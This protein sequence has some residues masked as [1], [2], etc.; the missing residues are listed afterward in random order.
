[1]CCGPR[2]A[3]PADR[4]W[5]P[6]GT[7]PTSSRWVSRAWTSRPPPPWP[8][9]VLVPPPTG[10]N[11]ELKQGAWQLLAAGDTRCISQ[12]ETPGMQGLLRRV[13]DA[14][15]GSPRPGLASLEDLAQLLALWRPGAYARERE[16]AYFTA[17]FGSQRPAL[18]HPSLAPIL[19]PTHGEL[20][21]ADQVVADHSTLRLHACLGRS[22][23]SRA[24]DRTPGG[25]L[26]HGARAQGRRQ[27][28]PLDRRAA[29]QHPGPAPG[30][31]RLP[32]RPRPRPGAREARLSTKPASSSIPPRARPS[33]PRP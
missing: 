22:L 31:R 30:A 13:R 14:A 6:P 33:S 28:P 9:P 24:G 27:A 29:Q 23:P 17:R 5:C 4:Y 7:N 21:Y 18:L 15:E 2:P 12:V 16:Q 20:L 26:R 11:D 10:F 8:P 32:V 3:S 19:G 1:M 25:A